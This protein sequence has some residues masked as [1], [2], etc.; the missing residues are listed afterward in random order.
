MDSVVL[1]ARLVLAGVF[2]VAAVGKLMDLPGSRRSLVGFGVPEWAAG[3]LGTVLPVAELAVAIALIPRPSAQWGAV[4]ALALLLAFVAGVGNA[5]RK[6]EAPPCNCFGAIHS[7][8]ASTK[9][10][11]RNIAL[12]AVAGVAVAW[13]SGPAI[14]TWVSDRT[15]AELVAI[16]TATALIALLAVGVPIWTE[17]RRLRTRLARAEERLAKVPPGLPVGS[18][19]PEFSVPDGEGGTMTLSAL[20]ARGKP[21]VLV[22][23]AAGCGP[24][25]PM[26]PNLRRLQ[27][28]AADRVTVALVGISTVVRYNAVREAH[29]G[30]RKLIDAIVED[31]VLKQEMDDLLEV[32]HRYDI[33][34]SPAAV[35]VT[36]AGTI[37]SS[38]VEARRGIE[39]LLRLAIAESPPTS[40]HRAPAPALPA[41]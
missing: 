9:T 2:V 16:V 10:L 34:H 26:L 39:A 28:I 14:D 3:V 41:V 31:P 13:G 18:P 8:P 37:G 23:T 5:L 7:E 24:C 33:H 21:V 36:P 35:L 15:A 29:G 11:I 40:V 6:G 25:E 30:D 32:S 17:T 4:G 27:S 22:F 1:A 19:A 20:L 12:A 38:A